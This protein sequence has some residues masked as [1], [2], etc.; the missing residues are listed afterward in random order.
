MLDCLKA[1]RGLTNIESVGEQEAPTTKLSHTPFKVWM[2]LS[3]MEAAHWSWGE[4]ITWMAARIDVSKAVCTHTFHISLPLPFPPNLLPPHPFPL[5]PPPFI[6]LHPPIHFISLWC[7]SQSSTE[8]IHLCM[9]LHSNSVPL[10]CTLEVY[11]WSVPALLHVGQ[12]LICVYSN[13]IWR[14]GTIT[15]LDY[16]T[17]LLD[18]TTGLDYWTGL[19][20]YWTHPN[21]KIHVV[22][23]RV[24][25]KHR[26]LF[27]QLLR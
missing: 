11:P 23:C 12:S 10:K 3:S 18:W 2:L 26:Y 22:Q 21:Y 16:W 24:E 20:D 9:N 13:R 14:V 27:T 19:L 6:C 1:T 8:T 4:W 7:S 17:G 25:A 15:G 5:P